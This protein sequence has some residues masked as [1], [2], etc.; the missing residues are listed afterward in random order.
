[1]LQQ[2]SAK[3]WQEVTLKCK[4]LGI[5]DKTPPLFKTH[6]GDIRPDQIEVLSNSCKVTMTT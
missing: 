3:A 2:L 4:K 5:D 6:A 1:M